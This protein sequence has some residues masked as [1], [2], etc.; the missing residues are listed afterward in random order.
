MLRGERMR[1]R[2]HQLQASGK[3][4]GGDN[5]FQFLRRHLSSE[6][7]ADYNAGHTARK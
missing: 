4:H 6:Q 3:S 5:K 7:A 2:P 1:S